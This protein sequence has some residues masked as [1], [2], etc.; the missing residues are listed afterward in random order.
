VPIQT[1]WL[2]A[3]ITTEP[4]QPHTIDTFFKGSLSGTTSG[5]E[6]QHNRRTASAPAAVELTDAA[7]NGVLTAAQTTVATAALGAAVAALKLSKMQ[8][9]FPHMDRFWVEYVHLL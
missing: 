4:K 5:D 8:C 7:H 2:L 6:T 3:G 1:Y 9:A